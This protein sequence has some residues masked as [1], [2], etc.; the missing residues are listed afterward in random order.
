MTSSTKPEVHKVLQ[1]GTELR[2]HVTCTENFVK[3]GQVVFWRPFVKPFALCY[4]T[5]VLSV[6]SKDLVIFI[7]GLYFYGPVLSVY[8]CVTLLYCGQTVGR[9]KMKFGMQV[10]LG[11]GHIVLH[12]YPV[13]PS[14]KGHSPAIFG[15]YLLWPNGCSL[16]G[17]RC[18]TSLVLMA[19]KQPRPESSGL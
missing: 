4:R 12:R 18:Q 9:I 8:L 3:F 15:P 13:P 14:L 17:S 6:L 1:T 2:P 16:H 11:P 5:V 7:Y 19:T 10:G